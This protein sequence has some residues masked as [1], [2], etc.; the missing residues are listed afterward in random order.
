[1]SKEYFQIKTSYS[2]YYAE[3]R[4]QH[5]I[6]DKV[7]I[8][9]GQECVSFSVYLDEDPPQLDGFGFS[10]HCDYT[11]NHIKG[12]GSVHLLNTAM[13][14]IV[15]HYKLH[16]DTKFELSDVSFIECIRYHL[17]LSLYYMI[18]DNKTWYESNF[19]ATPMYMSKTELDTQRQALKDY[20]SGKPDISS[21]FMERQS[22]L[23]DK[24]HQ[25]Y[26]ST[27]SLKECLDI[28]KQQDCNIFSGWLQSICFH[29]IP[30][31]LGTP[32]IIQNKSK[33]S[34]SYLKLTDKPNDI[35]QLKG[36]TGLYFRR[37]EL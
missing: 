37:D 35:F 18:Y 11:G 21:H 5:P 14:F 28:L 4:H 10:Q 1:M 9:A 30:H 31:L 33:E 20:I 29:H 36:E 6:V 23:K 16:E 17:P 12:I 22:A 34:I 3:I 26:N 2:S 15:S 8:G 7:Y 19:D 24:V 13:S 32:W 27:K 25:V